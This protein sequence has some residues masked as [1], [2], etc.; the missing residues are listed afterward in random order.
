VK[1][2]TIRAG[3]TRKRRNQYV[4]GG[5]P[6]ATTTKKSRTTTTPATSAITTSSGIL[7]P[8]RLQRTAS[9]GVMPSLSELP[10]LTSVTITAAGDRIEN[11][12]I[13][14]AGRQKPLSI[15]DTA[16]AAA[17]AFMLTM[18]HTED[19]GNQAG[20]NNKSGKGGKAKDKKAERAANKVFGMS[21][22][23]SS[24]SLPLHIIHYGTCV[25][26]CMYDNRSQSR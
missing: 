15:D 11:G 20:G 6:R 18:G 19:S 2:S 12:V 5:G 22:F 3:D 23:P 4:S 26:M 21:Y 13:I 17:R 9:G 7:R 16:A 10:S 25:C 8:P 24:L 14:P 1:P